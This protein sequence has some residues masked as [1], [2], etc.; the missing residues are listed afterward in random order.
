M[1]IYKC[2]FIQ[3]SLVYYQHFAT[4]L[5]YNYRFKIFVF[6]YIPPSK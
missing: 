1:D 3:S 2:M 6:T 5:W 4:A